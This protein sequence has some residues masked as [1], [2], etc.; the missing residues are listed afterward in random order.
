MYCY[1]H[2]T[3]HGKPTD[4]KQLIHAARRLYSYKKL[5]YGNDRKLPLST[6]LKVHRRLLKG[7]MAYSGTPEMIS[8]AKNLKSYADSLKHLGLKDHQ[9]LSTT[10]G[11]NHFSMFFLLPKLVYRL[12]KLTIISLL[13]L[14]GLLLFSPVFLLTS[15]ISKIKTKQAL[16]ESS[17]KVRGYDVMATWKIL[18]SAGLAPTFYT[19]YATLLVALNKH[20]YVYGLLPEGLSTW[21]IVLSTFIILPSITYAALIFGEQSLDLLKS[22]YPLILSLS[23]RSSSSL[24]S[25]R[26]ERQKLV[27]QVQACVIQFGADLFPDCAEKCNWRV[28]QPNTTPVVL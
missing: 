4:S 7:Y 1:I 24:Q 27:M 18:I 16:A 20:N 3:S 21:M 14:P 28:K 19:L 23:H 5:A 15:H 13:T 17:V 25:L 9:L 2:E 10:L 22:I 12:L 8:L 26:E 11:N 6:A